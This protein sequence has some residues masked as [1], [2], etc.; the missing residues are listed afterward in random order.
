MYVAS[1]RGSSSTKCFYQYLSPARELRWPE[2]ALLV[3]IL[4]TILSCAQSESHQSYEEHVHL[5][6]AHVVTLGRF[7]L[8]FVF[9]KAALLEI[10]VMSCLRLKLSE[11]VYNHKNIDE[12]QKV[13]AE[14]REA[15][16]NACR[17]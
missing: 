7:R 1:R 16:V 12:K 8:T 11:A 2:N 10:C 4:Q 9:L 15:P 17:A 5:R 6:S 3:P 13:N 14:R